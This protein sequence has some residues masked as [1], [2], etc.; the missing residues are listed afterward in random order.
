MRTKEISNGRLAMLGAAGMARVG[1]YASYWF[2]FSS[3]VSLLTTNLVWVP[4]FS[5]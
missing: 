1:L 4:F 3:I 5:C 2:C